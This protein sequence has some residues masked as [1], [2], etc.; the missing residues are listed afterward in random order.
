MRYAEEKIKLHN[1]VAYENAV[2]SVI[3]SG[4]LIEGSDIQ[5]AIACYE[6]MRD[7]FLSIFKANQDR[8]LSD[9][10]RF[11]LGMM[12]MKLNRIKRLSGDNPD[13]KITVEKYYSM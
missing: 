5:Y 12:T 10:D 2:K 7:A 4:D 13:V 11:V 1:K 3:V 8:Q 9:Y 6:K